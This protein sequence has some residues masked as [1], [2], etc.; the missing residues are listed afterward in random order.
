MNKM[1]KDVAQF[2]AACGQQNES[3]PNFR[4][5]PL[6]NLYFGLVCEEFQELDLAFENKDIVGIADGA[7]DLI[8]VI[9]GLCNALGIDIDSVWNEI[10]ASNMSKT[11]EGK[12]IKRA[13]GKILKPDTYFPPNIAQALGVEK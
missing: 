9:L 10:T 12:V 1:Q 6:A 5:T 3:A 7:G 11:V 8:W 13:D 4:D 2:M